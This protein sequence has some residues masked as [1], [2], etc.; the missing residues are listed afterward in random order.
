MVVIGDILMNLIFR[1]E[2]VYF[3]LQLKLVLFL[4][5]YL[6]CIATIVRVLQ[7]NHIGL[8]LDSA[9]RVFATTDS[10]CHCCTLPSLMC[11][12]CLIGKVMI[13]LFF[14]LFLLLMS[15]RLLT[16]IERTNQISSTAAI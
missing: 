5:R 11:L 10:W 8:L 9:D 1:P 14:N 13:S 16:S 7:S 4:S 3:C 15:C 12:L 6:N 2:L